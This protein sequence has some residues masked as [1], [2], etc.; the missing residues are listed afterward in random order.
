MADNN[1]NMVLR[2]V[3]L[4]VDVDRHLKNLAFAKGITKNELIRV[5]LRTGLKAY[6]GQTFG[7]RLAVA[8][9]PVKTVKPKKPDAQRRQAPVRQSALQL[10]E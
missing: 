1:E 7:E 2:T 5:I 6:E 3:Y 8:A 9:E 4:P 10:A